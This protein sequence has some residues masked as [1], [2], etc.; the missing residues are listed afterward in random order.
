MADFRY[1]DLGT[2][3]GG[4]LDCVR[5]RG[6][7]LGFLKAMPKQCLGI[8]CNPKYEQ[9]VR[10][11]G[12]HYEQVQ[13]PDSDWRWPS[14]DCYVAWNFLE[15]LDNI[16]DAKIVLRSMI[17]HS[18]QCV[19]L[20]LPSFEEDTRQRLLE[21]G[22]ELPW[23]RQAGHKALVTRQHV[24]QV[25]AELPKQVVRVVWRPKWPIRRLEIKDLVTIPGKTPKPGPIKP[26]LDGAWEGFLW[27][28]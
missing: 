16:E 21:R 24:L 26:C 14:A 19:W 9:D 27:K 1:V 17:Q 28:R 4:A 6:L 7:E 5:K 2:K 18:T 11:R 15:H 3:H 12:Y 25:V 22:F 13:L 23:Y 8:D 10:G 20:L